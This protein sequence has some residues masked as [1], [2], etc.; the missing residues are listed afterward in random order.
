MNSFPNKEL[1]E[2]EL[3][4]LI[5]KLVTEAGMLEK[6]LRNLTEKEVLEIIHQTDSQILDTLVGGMKASPQNQKGEFILVS[7]EAELVERGALS[8][9]NTSLHFLEHYPKYK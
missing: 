1:D 8:V 6:K 9:N 4:M 5:D 2:E 3:D 7:A